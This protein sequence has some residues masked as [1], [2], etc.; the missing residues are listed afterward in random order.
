MIFLQKVIVILTLQ[1]AEITS[2][3]FNQRM[4]LLIIYRVAQ[5]TAGQSD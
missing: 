3:L 4:H 1:A 2:K 5:R